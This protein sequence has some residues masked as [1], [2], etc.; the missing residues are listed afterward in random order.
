MKLTRKEHIGAFNLIKKTENNQKDD[1]NLA[2]KE[3]VLFSIDEIEK[4]INPIK[5]VILG[6]LDKF[7]KE[8]ASYEKICGYKKGDHCFFLFDLI[9]VNLCDKDNKSYVESV[10]NLISKYVDEEEINNYLNNEEE[11]I[12]LKIEKINRDNL[13]NSIDIKLLSFLTKNNLKG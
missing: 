1:F 6:M 7:F 5:K 10:N 3:W 2:F 9:P 11:K 13:P 12:E 4:I 8:K